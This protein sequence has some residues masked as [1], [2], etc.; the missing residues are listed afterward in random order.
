MLLCKTSGCFTQQHPDVFTFI[1]ACLAEHYK[2]TNYY[3]H[4]NGRLGVN[5]RKER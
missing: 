4:T 5:T 3:P 2:E 1:S